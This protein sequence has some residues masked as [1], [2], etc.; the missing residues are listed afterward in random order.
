MAITI[1]TSEPRAINAGETALWQ[2]PDLAVSYPVATWTLNYHLV[3]PTRINITA[4]N[5]AGV[6]EVNVN[7]ATTGAWNAGTYAVYA[8]VSDGTS[9][10]PVAP[11]FP[12]LEVRLDPAA[13]DVPPLA[14]VRSWAAQT[15][16]A[17][18]AAIKALAGKIVAQTTINGTTYTLADLDKLRRLEA[19]MAARVQSEQGG[20]GAR[21]IY[22]RF[23]R[24]S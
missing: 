17:V 3:G 8:R 9:V 16:D 23:T 21:L 22:A 1:P 14:D 11:T 13:Q 19:D 15:L 24:P 7:A 4:A 12:T 5:N 20:T 6:H 18:R 2:R 10:F